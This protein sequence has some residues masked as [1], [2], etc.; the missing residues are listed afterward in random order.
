MQKRFN[1]CGSCEQPRDGHPISFGG[2]GGARSPD[3]KVD[4]DK[5]PAGLWDVVPNTHEETLDQVGGFASVT[6][7]IQ[8]E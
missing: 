5:D 4:L 8:Y 3:H 6:D 1:W 2:V 7:T